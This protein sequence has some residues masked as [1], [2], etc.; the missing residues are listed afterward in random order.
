MT[1]D[2]TDVI[3]AITGNNCKRGKAFAREEIT[4]PQRVL[5]S[6][7]CLKHAHHA[8]LLPV[9][10]TA[11]FARSLHLQAMEKLRTVTVTAP[12][13]M[14]DIIIP[15]ILNTGVDIVASCDAK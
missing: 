13:K 11:T 6:T 7:V 5:T 1:L 8:V 14:G 4:C 3:M 15:N 9:R 2:D 12:V 10:S